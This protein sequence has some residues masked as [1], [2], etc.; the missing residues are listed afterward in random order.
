MALTDTTEGRI[1]ARWI[2]NSGLEPYLPPIMLRLLG[3]ANQLSRY[4]VISALALGVDFACYL[5]LADAKYPA[6]I[7]GVIGYAIGM[8]L[9]FS[10]STRYVFKKQACGK[11]DGRLFTEFVIS[12]AAGIF[13]TAAVI[14]VATGIFHLSAL[15]AKFCAVA[16]SFIGVFLLRRSVVFAPR[17]GRPQ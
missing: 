10:L 11:S 6:P 12:G 9:H 8:L 3:L 16:I 14:T 17:A 7:A 4:T 1:L 15:T 5:A 2:A 13:L